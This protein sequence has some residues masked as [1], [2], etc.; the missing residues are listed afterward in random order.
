VRSALHDV[1]RRALAALATSGT[2]EM[3]LAL[4]VAG[5]ATG[6]PFV[7][8]YAMWRLIDRKDRFG[9]RLVM[10]LRADGIGLQPPTRSIA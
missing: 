6:R 7:A 3:L 8:D 2:G 4:A 1:R 10:T 5:L 9:F